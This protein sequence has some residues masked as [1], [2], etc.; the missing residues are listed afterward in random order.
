MVLLQDTNNSET[1][2]WIVNRATF[3]TGYIRYQDQGTNITRYTTIYNKYRTEDNLANYKK[4]RNI[5][6]NFLRKTKAEYSQKL[7]VKDLSDNRKFR[8][9]IKPF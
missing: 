3:Y 6:L 7:N 8:K 5:C 1:T 9:T 2:T 4:Q